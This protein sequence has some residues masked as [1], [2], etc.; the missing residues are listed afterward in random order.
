MVRDAGVLVDRT[1]M[2]SGRVRAALAAL[3]TFLAGAS[4]AQAN[5]WP[6]PAMGPSH[7]GDPEV[8]FTFDDG[9]HPIITPR[10]LDMLQAH[11]IHAVFFWVG[12]RL[13]RTP[14]AAGLLV[15]RAI[16]E[17]HI[18]GNHTIN[19][20][21]LCDVP[22]DIGA[23]EIEGARALFEQAAQ[24][25]VVWFRSPYGARC[26]KLERMLTDRGLRNFHWDLDP[27]EWRSYGPRKTIDYVIRNLTY[28]DQGQRAVLLLHD[29]KVSTLRAFPKIID[30]IVA[31][32][33]KRTAMGRRPIRI[34]SAYQLA[35]EQLDRQAVDWAVG[36][37]EEAGGSMARALAATVP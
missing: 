29:T 6:Q 5:G 31:E 34:V 8:I 35:I 37:A 25:P 18:V 23:R 26:P 4:P 11:D 14:E 13:I 32:N 19:H 27:Q 33:K 2:L 17:G 10:L 16:R 22:E 15:E 24:M 1:Q 20:A 3:L 9:P 12:W 21:Q 28:L 7:S 36:A 30:W